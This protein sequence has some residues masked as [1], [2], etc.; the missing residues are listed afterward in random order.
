[1]AC[2]EITRRQDRREGLRYASGLSD[3]EWGIAEAIDAFLS[4]IGRS[5]RRT[6]EP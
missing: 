1:M 5:L 3:T 4:R 2:T 6:C